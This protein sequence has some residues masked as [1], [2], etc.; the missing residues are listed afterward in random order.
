MVNY[1]TYMLGKLYDKPKLLCVR[2]LLSE[3]IKIYPDNIEINTDISKA[4][5]NNSNILVQS[6]TIKNDAVINFK[7]DDRNITVLSNPIEINVTT[8]THAIEMLNSFNIVVVGRLCEQKNLP[9]IL[10]AFSLLLKR[11]KKDIGLHFVGDGKEL[12]ELKLL[13]ASLNLKNHVLFHGY[14]KN[15]LAYI[16]KADLLILASK[17]EGLPNVILEAFS[18]KTPVLASDIHVIKELVKD[19]E[20]GVLF[21]DNNIDDLSD[22]MLFCLTNDLNDYITKAYKSLSKYEDVHKQFEQLLKKIVGK[23]EKKN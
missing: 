6:E 1:I 23:Y 17:Y 15:A 8:N 2:N 14:K 5:F 21:K 9:L 4:I 20:T 22:K 13:A 7:A 3:Q 18:Q 12:K 11:Y 16:T 19:K 10:K